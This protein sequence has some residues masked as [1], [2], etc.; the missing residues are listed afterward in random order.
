MRT[1]STANLLKEKG[2]VY[3]L[4]K[5][6]YRYLAKKCSEREAL[7]REILSQEGILKY[8]DRPASTKEAL[9]QAYPFE[10][11]AW[12]VLQHHCKLILTLKP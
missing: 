3:T 6:G 8:E 2:I 12:Q 7:I 1:V 4:N 5:L 10:K 9:A 11:K